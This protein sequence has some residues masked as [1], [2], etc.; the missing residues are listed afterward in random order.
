M[1]KGDAYTEKLKSSIDTAMTNF[2]HKKRLGSDD[3]AP[4]PPPGLFMFAGRP[5]IV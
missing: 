5:A 2:W 1:S 4:W 3:E